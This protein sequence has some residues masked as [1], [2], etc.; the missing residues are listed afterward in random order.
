M[1]PSRPGLS[2]TEG[3]PPNRKDGAEV[4]NPK[5]Q[6]LI[7]ELARFGVAAL[8]F[9]GDRPLLGTEVA[10]RV[11][12]ADGSLD[13]ECSLHEGRPGTCAPIPGCDGEGRAHGRVGCV[14]Q[15][16]VRNESCNVA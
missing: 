7:V 9:W 6:W 8:A 5:P 4:A 14:K 3:D 10:E 16:L 11:A 12:G 2:L 15:P 13:A 1:F